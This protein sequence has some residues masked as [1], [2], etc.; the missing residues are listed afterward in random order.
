MVEFIYGTAWKKERTADLVAR[1]LATGFR[2]IDTANQ[3]KHY[4]EPGVGEALKR[5]FAAG[6]ARESLFIQTK[7]TSLDGQDDRVPYDPHADI[8]RQVE[9]SFESSC[10]H[11]HVEYFDSYLL[12]G[13]YHFP[14]LGAED[15]EVWSKMEEFFD[16]GL[17]KRIG[18]SNVNELQLEQ[19]VSAAR[20]RP[21]FVQNRCFASRDWDG[22]VRELCQKYE[23]QYQGFSL[24]TANPDVVRGVAA[25]K[26]SRSRG[27]TPAQVVFAFARAIG[28]I[29]LTG[30]TDE[31]HMAQDLQSID[32]HL[33]P[34]EIHSLA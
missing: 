15:F 32:V 12:H 19:L 13:P 18:V 30:T 20:V 10:R 21:H 23:I 4:H 27:L 26:I 9:E 17:V 8:K 14:G 2:A 25:E 7:F 11:L 3:P 5:F 24:L 22:R 34:E 29:P 16:R 33:N 28:I 1:A 6:N 31:K